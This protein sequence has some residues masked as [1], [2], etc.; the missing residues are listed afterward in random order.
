LATKI[1]P[2]QAVRA[3]PDGFFSLPPTSVR[4]ASMNKDNAVNQAAEPRPTLTGTAHTL[5]FDKLSP[6]DFERLCLWLVEAEGY[7]DAEHLGAAGSEQGR[8]VVARRKGV[9]WAFQ[10]KRVQS[11]GPTDA[12]RE[13]EKVLGLP[14]AERPAGLIFLVTC[15]VSAR[16]R[17]QVRQACAEEMACQFWTGTELD[18]RV[19]RHSDIVAEFFAAGA[20]GSQ[21]PRPTGAGG[22]GIQASHRGVAQSGS[23][24]IAITGDVQGGLTIVQGGAGASGAGPDSATPPDSGGY[25]LAAVRDLLLAAFTAPDLRRLFLYTSNGGLR[26]L[27]REFSPNDGPAAMVERTIEFCLARNLLPD[28]LQEVERVNPRQY[29]QYAHRLRA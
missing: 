22:P 11:F 2:Q 7:E 17:Q 27:L 20:S 21:E 12:L 29:A 19:K 8:D 10:C 28:L 26:P 24:N 14:Q 9:Q 6:R 13:V 23:G 18:R 4:I 15:D 25:D 16:T 3:E 5:P 1:L